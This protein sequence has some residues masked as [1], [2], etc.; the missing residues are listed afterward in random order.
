MTTTTKG[1]YAAYRFNEAS[2]T[3]LLD[4]T[5]S[6]KLPNPIESKE[7]HV[8]LLYSTK[9]L[10]DYKPRGPITEEV[11]LGEFRVFRSD[12]GRNVLTVELLGSVVTNRHLHLMQKHQALYSYDRYIP[13]VT[14]SYDIGE[15]VVPYNPKLGTVLTLSEEYSE[16]LDL[17]Y[18]EKTYGVENLVVKSPLSSGW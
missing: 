10:P 12:S 5:T 4:L 13:H 17:D 7:L 3:L 8:T 15:L 1:T 16:D 9:H 6:L 14:L 2:K 11:T 18:I